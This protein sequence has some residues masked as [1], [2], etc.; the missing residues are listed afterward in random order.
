MLQQENYYNQSGR[1]YSINHS[2]F[3]H[4][5]ILFDRKPSLPSKYILNLTS[6]LLTGVKSHYFLEPLKSYL[7]CLPWNHSQH[8]GQCIPF[9]TPLQCF[10][11]QKTRFLQQPPP[12]S[13]FFLPLLSLASLPLCSSF[14]LTAPW[15]PTTPICFWRA[16][17]LLFLA[18]TILFLAISYGYLIY[19]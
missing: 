14:V 11:S 3:S 9:H 5:H 17:S 1:T 6:S 12:P 15:T 10:Y 7:I 4:A 8:S 13:P 2:S 19:W 18:P 16:L